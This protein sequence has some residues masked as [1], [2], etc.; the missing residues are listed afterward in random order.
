M[1]IERNAYARTIRTYKDDEL[2]FLDETE[3]NLHT[4]SHFGYAL[5]GETP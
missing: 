3:F 5:S 4:T 1:T 2:I